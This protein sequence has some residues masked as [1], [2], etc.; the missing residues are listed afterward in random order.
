MAIL[1]ENIILF[2]SGRKLKIQNGNVAI[3]C[4]LE[5]AQ[6]YGAPMLRYDSDSGRDPEVDPVYNT[7]FLTSEEAAELAD[8]AI[9]LWSKLK[10]NIL[11]HGVASTK[12]FDR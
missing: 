10:A 9:Q 7:H 11:E 3:N 12:I 1:K 8:C 5:V 6:G 2:T 4:F